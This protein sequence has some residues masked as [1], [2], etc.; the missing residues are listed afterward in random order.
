MRLTRLNECGVPLDP[1]AVNSRIQSQQFVMVEGDPQ[2][3]KSNE[4]MLQ[5]ACSRIR[6]LFYTPTRLK[7]MNV[8]LQ[9]TNVSLP[10]LEML[11]GVSLQADADDPTA[12]IG[13]ALANQLTSS[14]LNPV[15]LEVQGQNANRD[16]CGLGGTG[17]AALAWH[18]FPWTYNWAINDKLTI[19]NKDAF[20]VTLQG[21]ALN[22]P[23]WFPS[24]PGADFPSWVPGGGS[25]SSANVPSGPAP[26]VIPA[27]IPAD[28][29]TLDD[30]EDFQSAGPYFFRT[31]STDY[32]FSD[33]W[34]CNFV[35]SGS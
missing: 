12:F 8:Q 13:Y 11:L 10:I 34:E 28:P 22:N 4:I 9:L 33:A 2:N 31:A 29:F 17:S 15:M 30:Q 25:T 18:V 16:E 21:I 1:L 3:E 26:A 5:D 35:D 20:T 23:N 6:T 19:N 7:S 32:L 14:A 24:F 27:N